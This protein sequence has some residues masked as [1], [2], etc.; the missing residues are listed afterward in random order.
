MPLPLFLAAAGSALQG[1]STLASGVMSARA[2]KAAAQ[3][4]RIEGEIAMIRRNQQGAQARQELLTVLQSIGAL[5]SAR[6][7]SLDSP[8]GQVI[9]RATRETAYRQEAIAGLAEL[10]RASAAQQEARGHRT[11]ARWAVPISVLNSA[12]SFAQAG[13]YYKMGMNALKLPPKGVG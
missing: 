1:V 13:S 2:S 4:S 5:R 8:T 7:V 10:N 3:A 9:E 6:G 11:A 12:G